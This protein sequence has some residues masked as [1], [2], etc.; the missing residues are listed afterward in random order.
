MTD[1]GRRLL[2]HASIADLSPP[3]RR[4]A[5]RNVPGLEED[6]PLIAD[7]ADGLGV[8]TPLLAEPGVTDVLVNGCGGVWVERDGRL[9][10][11]PVQVGGA[12]ALLDLLFH[13]FGRAGARLDAAHPIA[14]LRLPDG[15]R[16]HA[17]LPPIAPEGP[18]VSIRVAPRETFTLSDLAARGTFSGRQA[19]I[20]RRAVKESR[21]IVVSGRTGSGK[22]TLTNALL[23]EVPHSERVVT[24][25][26]T[27][28][29]RFAH[30]HHVSLVT[31]PESP[32]GVVA[33]TPTD[34]LRA[35]LRMR[36]DRIVVGEA[37]GPEALV[38]LRAF[39]SGHRGSIVTVHARD[40]AYALVRLRHLALQAS[41]APTEEAVAAEVDDAVDVCVHID[42][43]PTGRRVTE[44]IERG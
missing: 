21:T 42:R 38:A 16:L 9:E 6:A 7:V 1:L 12:E 13:A 26:E 14:D 44:V 5:L 11:V 28:E 34:L 40:A 35:A 29:L 3:E 19:E 22:T 30:P 41:D 32:E 36:P 24:I 15:S 18:V 23:H 25:E 33:V 20:L 2:G 43:T 31:R 27:R 37:R 10:E 4:L 39:A 8:L 17:V